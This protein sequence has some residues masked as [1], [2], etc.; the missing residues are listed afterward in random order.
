MPATCAQSV[1]EVWEGIGFLG[2]PASAWQAG[3]GDPVGKWITPSIW[4]SLLSRAEYEFIWICLL[5]YWFVW[6]SLHWFGFTL[7]YMDSLG[8]EQ[9]SI[10][11][12]ASVIATVS[13]CIVHIRF[14]TREGIRLQ[15]NSIL[16]GSPLLNPFSQTPRP[17]T[18][19]PRSSS[20][21]GVEWRYLR[22]GWSKSLP[23]NNPHLLLITPPC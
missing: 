13:L 10:D 23:W 12:Y 20:R 6:V 16:S 9:T 21:H 7:I 3:W 8:M 4:L 2:S 14:H 5:F 22:Q 19:C 15:G 17:P 1:G 11:L 18:P